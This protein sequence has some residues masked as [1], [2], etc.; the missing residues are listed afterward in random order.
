MKEKPIIEIRIAEKNQ[1]SEGQLQDREAKSTKIATELSSASTPAA[2]PIF[3]NDLEQGVKYM[4]RKEN[5]EVAR[6]TP[7]DSKLFNPLVLNVR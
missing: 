1:E 4:M 2:T 5:E 3:I 6:M 7:A